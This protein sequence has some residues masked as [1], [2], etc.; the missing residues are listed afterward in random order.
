MFPDIADEQRHGV[1]DRQVLVFLRLQDEQLVGD[2]LIHEDTPA[3]GLDSFR[4]GGKLALAALDRS[5]AL[6]HGLG[7]G[8]GDLGLVRAHG[9]PEQCVQDVTA[10]VE[11]GLQAQAANGGE[12]AGL[13]GRFHLLQGVVEPLDIT[14]MMLVVVNADGLLIIE[15]FQGVVGVGQGRQTIFPRLVGSLERGRRGG[16]RRPL[17]FEEAPLRGQ[18]S[19]KRR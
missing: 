2:R 3:A 14:G 1:P 13:A 6:L 19:R 5:E 15:G 7:E 11:G 17:S 12:I 16:G 9:M 18:Y 8:G 4:G 10:A